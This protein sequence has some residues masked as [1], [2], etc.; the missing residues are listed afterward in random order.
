MSAKWMVEQHL[1]TGRLVEILHGYVPPHR[2][3]HAVLPRQGGLLP[4]VHAFV[5]LL[6]ECCEG[7]E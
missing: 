2:A 6:Q 3:M 7:V 1:A 4:K 5:D